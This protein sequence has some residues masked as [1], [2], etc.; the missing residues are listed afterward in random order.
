[1]SK[2]QVVLLVVFGFFIIAAVAV[3]SLYHG[4]SSSQASVILWGSIPSAQFETLLGDPIYTSD[5]T[6]DVHYVERPAAT[7]ESD[8]TNALAQ[9][10]GPDLIILPQNELWQARNKLT[11]I[12]YGSVSERTF[13]DTFADG[14]AVFL[15]SNGIAA[16]PLLAD[17][18]VLYFNRD[19]I[20]GAGLAQP[21]AYWDQV[22]DAAAKLTA[23]DKAG[24]ITR[25]AISFGDWRNIPDAKSLLSLLFLQAGTPITALNNGTLN[26][27]LLA[28]GANA[29]VTPAESALDFYTQFANP[30][31]PFYSWNRTLP[32]AP[33]FFAAGDLAYY[34]GFASELSIIK[35]KSP[36][37]NFGVAPVPQ[38]RVANQKLT[39]GTI[40]GIALSRGAGNPTAALTAALKI[41]SAASAG[42]LSQATNLPPVRRDLLVNK[43]TD[44]VGPV[45][46]DAALQARTWLD[47]NPAQT[48]S[49]FFD[50]ID[51]VTSGRAR[52]TEALSNANQRLDQVS[53]Q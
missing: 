35:S 21:I 17:P 44:A 3:F 42:K 30:S 46:Y 34:V 47:P 43:P 2:F 15:T 39:T 24:N 52:T 38:S 26:S 5:R 16:L 25:S 36:T 22:Y 32:D 4:G 28:N 51:A 53:K 11:V 9:G 19:M 48:T 37:L 6:V 49:I 33:T 1:M 45:F 7:L 41:V 12:P 18:L 29:P 50:A 10:H 27:A 13:R 40:Y 14:S 20:S 23:I 31:K 8:F